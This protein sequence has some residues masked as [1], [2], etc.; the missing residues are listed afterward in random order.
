MLFKTVNDKQARQTIPA[1]ITKTFLLSE[2]MD[3]EQAQIETVTFSILS[4]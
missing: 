4:F 3:H 2:L 1:A